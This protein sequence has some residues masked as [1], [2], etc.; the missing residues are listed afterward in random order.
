MSKIICDVCGTRYPDSS[1]QC[2]IC[3]C[4]RNA[5]QMTA[6]TDV[7]EEE[8]VTAARSSV[9]GGRFSKSNVRKRNKNQPVYEE[10]ETPA[11]APAPEAD[12][13]DYDSFE[14]LEGRS[15]RK[16][17][18]F[19]N[20][21]LVL[22]I[23]A[24]L[25]V[26]AC[27]FLKYVMPNALDG[28]LNQNPAEA[29]EM[30]DAPTEEAT[31]TATEALQTEAAKISCEQLILDV[32]DITLTEEGQM[33]LL[34]VLTLPE[35]TTDT[36]MYIS[37]NEDVATVNEEGRVTAVGEGSVV[38]SIF[39]GEQQT[40]CNVIC[41]FATEAP[42]EAATEAPAEGETQAPA[43]GETEAPAEGE[44]EAP[45]EGETEAPAEGET[46]APTEGPTEPLKDV[47]LKVKTSDMTFRA[48]GQQ[49]VIKLLCELTNQEVTWTS[50]NE[51]VATVDQ[52]GV[53]T[54]IGAGTTIIT[55]QYGD[56][57][58]EIIVRCP[59]G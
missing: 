39:C 30:T 7:S 49:A 5:E 59:R 25:V 14:E 4:I 51:S 37:S 36:I 42:T 53:I 54:R 28:I 46:E 20:I 27:I 58:V 31:Q 19:L 26:S 55:G 21:M 34:N 43:E 18:V 23:V 47:V 56:Q 24:L 29:T 9:R 11:P 35:D 2:P 12:E 57:K 1:N 44:T 38:I 40:E 10:S 3:G 22:V 15:H 17:N 41:T 33:Y 32:T 45:S 6:E 52:D 16:K 13:E 48:R 8:L 50:A